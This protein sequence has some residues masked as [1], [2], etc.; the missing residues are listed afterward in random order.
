MHLISSCVSATA[1]LAMA[2]IVCS[3]YDFEQDDVTIYN[4]MPIHYFPNLLVTRLAGH[5]LASPEV[6]AA[7]VQVV[8]G[9]E[10]TPATALSHTIVATSAVASSIYGLIATSPNDPSR[11][12]IDWDLTIFIP[13]LLIGVSIGTKTLCLAA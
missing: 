1:W 10:L 4:R 8:L 7:A 2:L 13:A 11:T 12:L 3:G 6:Q 9:F 5:A